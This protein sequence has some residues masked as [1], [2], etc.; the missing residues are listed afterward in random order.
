[1][2][3]RGPIALILVMSAALGS[4]ATGLTWSPSICGEVRRQPVLGQRQVVHAV[5]RGLN[6]EN[7]R[8]YALGDKALDNAG[9]SH[10][11]PAGCCGCSSRYPAARSSRRFYRYGAA[12][13]SLPSSR[14]RAACRGPAGSHGVSDAPVGQAAQGVAGAVESAE[15]RFSR[16]P[17]R[18]KTTYQV[19]NEA[20]G[21]VEGSGATQAARRSDRATLY[22]FQVP[23][24]RFVVAFA[25]ARRY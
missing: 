22:R 19:H 23:G 1:M 4:P 9:E 14:V 5:V 11:S 17:S 24:P 21:L 6:G 15:L 2:A 7:K 8:R 12:L 18:S 20:L 10:P 16:V 13:N 25:A 3:L